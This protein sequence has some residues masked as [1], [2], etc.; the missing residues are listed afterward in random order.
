MLKAVIDLG[1][2]NNDAKVYIF[3]ATKAP[4]K[5]NDIA[6]ALRMNKQ[7][8]YPSLKNL[9]N[10]GIVNCSCEYPIFSPLCPW[11]KP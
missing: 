9:Q 1:L 2:S 7:R 11:K 3:L 5:A 10:R 6:E 8:L 4:Q